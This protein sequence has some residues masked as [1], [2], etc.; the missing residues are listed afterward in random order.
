MASVSLTDQMGAMA[1]ID[2]LRHSQ[3]EVQKHLDL[4]ERRRAVAE[5][6][7]EFYKAKGVDVQAGLVEQGVKDYF[8]ARLTY[9]APPIGPVTRLLTRVYIT[10]GKW[11]KPV[12]LVL[13]LSAVAGVGIQ[14]AAHW[15]GEE[16]V[17]AAQ[18]QVDGI[19]VHSRLLTGK[20]EQLRKRAIQ[21][22]PE[23]AGSNLP[24][25]GRMLLQVVVL[26]DKAQG[27]MLTTVPAKVTADSRI[28]DL[29][30][31]AMAS[32]ALEEGTSTLQTAD[33]QLSDITELLSASLKLT[34]LSTGDRFAATS[35]QH[36]ALAIAAAHARSAIAQADTKGVAAARNSVD[37]VANLLGRA[38]AIDPFL[39]QLQ[40]AQAAVHDMGLSK[41]DADQFQ[42]LFAKVDDAI[43]WLDVSVAE[44]ALQEVEQL[45]RFASTALK[46]NVVSRAGEKS[47]IER[48]FDP[49]GGKT[50]YLLTE[51]TDSAG[52]VVSVPVTSA[53]TGK[54]RF[55]K[56]F[57][58]RVSQAAYIE[59]KNDKLADGRVDNSRMGVKDANS[60]TLK[61]SE[62]RTSANPDYILEW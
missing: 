8:A 19:R 18:N 48:N 12:I 24:A 45:K 21:L 53:E 11:L 36:A 31:A 23:V 9:D 59:A 10:R 40:E 14:V 2:E 54:K 28:G 4:P 60:L 44:R 56:V 39:D 22:Q 62:G 46:L 42:P 26:L 58:V 15:I 5:R 37:L 57:G 32:K 13:A 25:A 41:V 34:A 17:Q 27:Q 6:I 7:R 47:M 55:A 61:F 33:E 35:R 50:W 16:R 51:A 3:M 49:T 52:N 43:K 38:T 30:L 29:N 20:V 1:L